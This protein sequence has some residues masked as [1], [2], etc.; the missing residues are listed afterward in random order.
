MVFQPKWKNPS[1][2]RTYYAWR[3]MRIRCA[4]KS[5]P[6]YG[7]RGI[8]V[9]PAWDDY[10][11][12]YADMGECP[13]GYSLDRIDNNLG[14]TPLNCRWATNRE[15]LNNQRR[16]RVIDFNGKSQTLSYWAE[17]L[18]V[19]LD[20]LHRRLHRLPLERAMV[21]GSIRPIWQHGSRQGYTKGCRCSKCKDA[22]NLRMRE[23]R[24]KRKQYDR[25][26][27]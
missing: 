1:G 24:R 20:T 10:D 16:N 5:N 4:D 26:V 7:G 19:S 8:T 17:E 3:S 25:L 13:I 6:N 18:G 11:Q 2:T 12:F 27:L 15:Q 23:L 22:H 9:I 21:A 14:Y